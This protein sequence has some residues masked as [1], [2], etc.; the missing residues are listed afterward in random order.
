MG[1]LGKTLTDNKMFPKVSTMIPSLAGKSLDKLVGYF[2]TQN[3]ENF[4][5]FHLSNFPIS[6][7]QLVLKK[8]ILKLKFIRKGNNLY[9]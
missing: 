9:F 4:K 3:M 6:I 2:P 1:Q 8:K 5:V 7:E